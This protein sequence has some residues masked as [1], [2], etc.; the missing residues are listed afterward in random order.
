MFENFRKIKA[1]NYKF[2]NFSSSEKIENITFLIATQSKGLLLYNNGEIIQLFN[3]KGFYGIT[4]HN[5]L[6]FAFYKTGMHG[7]I[8]SFKLQ[9]N[10][11]INVKVI[12]KG[13]SRGVHQIDFIGNN[14]YVT[15]T[16]D[17]SI[18]IYNN[19]NKKENIHW[20]NY[21]NIIFQME[22]YKM[23]ENQ[24]ITTISTPSMNI[25]KK[26][27]LIAHNETKKTKEKV[28]LYI[29]ETKIKQ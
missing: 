1:T 22:N 21:N 15:N 26:L 16:Y 18:L 6:Y 2:S 8:I 4:K 24:V 13:L 10:Q 3:K 20:R 25:E 11:A 17:N 7:N 23:E 27:Y 14:L 12:I 19:A 28:N 9:N 29:I 5:H